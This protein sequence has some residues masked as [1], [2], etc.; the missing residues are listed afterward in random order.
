MRITVELEGAL[1][2]RVREAAAREGVA[3]DV[4]VRG[5][6]ERELP[7]RPAAPDAEFPDLRP[8]CGTAHVEETIVKPFREWARAHGLGGDRKP[9]PSA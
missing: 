5:L 3:V 2:A 4:Y 9:R 7:G 6:L 1:E 8:A